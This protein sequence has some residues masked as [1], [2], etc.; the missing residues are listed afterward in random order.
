M[1]QTG[2]KKADTVDTDVAL[3]ILDASPD[4]IKLLELDGT[5][6][7]MSRNGL[8][9]MEIDDFGA[10]Q[11]QPWPALWPEEARDLLW[12]AVEDAKLGQAREFEAFC[13]TAKG[14]PR[15]WRVSVAPVRG[16][17]GGIE[18]LLA[19][20]R[21]VT[22]RVDHENRLRE[23]D[24]QLQTYAER[25]TRE[26]AEKDGLLAHQRALMAEIDH[27]VKN[28][29]ALVGAMLRMQRRAVADEGARTALDESAQR[30]GTLARLHEQLHDS[31]DVQAVRLD[32]YLARL[33]EDMREGLA[34][35]GRV[36]AHGLPDIALPPR[37][38]VTLGLVVCELVG[39]AL[40]HARPGHPPSVEVRV[41][42][43]PD[44]ALTLTVSDDGTGL[45]DGFVMDG[46][47]GL[48][49]RLCL[50]FAAELGGTLDVERRSPG[51][52]FRLQVPPLA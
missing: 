29:F 35:R 10:V 11:G 17:G 47:Q 5:L 39:N 14:N 50:T 46:A 18:R 2:S 44:G 25:L 12:S 42:A 51:A 37:R 3:T 26:L 19:S 28:G 27:R 36:E 1:T 34:G 15:W 41:E 6:A 45:P 43:A 49:M 33:L 7:Y 31:D 23:R 9:A 30:I 38:A 52:A 24:L 4:C 21:D 22:E 48:G 32:D 16:E 40:K 20:S 13:P 8:C